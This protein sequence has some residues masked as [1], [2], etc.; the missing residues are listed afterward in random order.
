MTLIDSSEYDVRLYVASVTQLTAAKECSAAQSVRRLY[1]G[2][3]ASLPG[4][5]RL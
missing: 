2:N 4:A 5:G 1:A 3:P